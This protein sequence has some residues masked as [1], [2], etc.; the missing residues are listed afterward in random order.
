M[1]VAAPAIMPDRNP[2]IV[3]LRGLK[4]AT[5]RAAATEAPSV[6]EP[7][8]VISGKANTRKLRKTPRASRDRM[9]PIVIEPISRL[10]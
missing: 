9:K 4:P 1:P 7:S 2:A 6:I 10:M 3:A 5:S 8:A